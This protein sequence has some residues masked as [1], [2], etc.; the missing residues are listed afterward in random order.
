[1]TTIVQLLAQK[2]KLMERL[3]EITDPKE[4]VQIERLFAEI[5]EDLNLLDAEPGRPNFAKMARCAYVRRIP[6]S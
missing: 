2:Q 1:M 3:D 5:D 4:R 6:V